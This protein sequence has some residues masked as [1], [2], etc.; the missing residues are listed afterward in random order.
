MIILS[1]E[2]L[3]W[4]FVIKMVMNKFCKKSQ[5]FILSFLFLMLLLVFISSLETKNTYII[6][7]TENDIVENIVYETCMIARMS[8]GTYIENRFVEFSN[9][10][11]G[12]CN[13]KGIYCL[14][15]IT[16]NTQ[17]PTNLSKINYTL[18]DYN[19]QLNTSQYYHK[20]NFTC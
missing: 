5:F 17:I 14:L 20:S 12:Y 2:K 13:G 19:I 1:L 7:G 6:K 10:V 8:N 9:D 15:N 18:F 3:F 4:G 16:N 11:S